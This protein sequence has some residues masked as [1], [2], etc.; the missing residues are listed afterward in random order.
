MYHFSDSGIYGRKKQS[1]PKSRFVTSYL[2]EAV[3]PMD[4]FYK[5]PHNPLTI[6]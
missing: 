1:G 4:D 3:S 5:A 2:A 6:Y